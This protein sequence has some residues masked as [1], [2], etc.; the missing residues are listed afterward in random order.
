[1]GSKHH[2]NPYTPKRQPPRVVHAHHDRHLRIHF[3]YTP[4]AKEPLLALA[5]GARGLAPNLERIS[6]GPSW[7][8]FVP[9]RVKFPLSLCFLVFGSYSYTHS[10]SFTPRECVHFI[11]ATC[12]GFSSRCYKRA[13]TE[14]TTN[15]PRSKEPRTTA[16]YELTPTCWDF[17]S[18]R[19]KR[20]A[21][22]STTN[23]QRL[24]EPRT[25]ASYETI[26]GLVSADILQTSYQHV[27]PIVPNTSTSQVKTPW[28][29]A[30]YEPKSHAKRNAK[31]GCREKTLPFLPLL[32][33]LPFEF[34]T[35]SALAAKIP[36]AIFSLKA[37]LSRLC[38][39]VPCDGRME[40]GTVAKHAILRTRTAER[41]SIGDKGQTAQK[42]D[43]KQETNI[44]SHVPSAS[45]HS[46]A[47]P[48]ANTIVSPNRLSAE[49]AQP[50]L[51]T[52][53]RRH[54]AIRYRHCRART[55]TLTKSRRMSGARSQRK[56]PSNSLREAL[57][58]KQLQQPPLMR[59]QRDAEKPQD[60][61][62][63]DESYW[64]NE[65]D[66]R[67]SSVHR[68][69]PFP[70]HL[71]PVCPAQ[72]ATSTSPD[73][74]FGI[75]GPSYLFH[76]H[77]EDRLHE[78]EHELRGVEKVNLDGCGDNTP[79]LLSQPAEENRYHKPGATNT[80]AG[81]DV[82]ASHELTVGSEGRI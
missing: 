56:T 41:K 39:E 8:L 13:A 65:R 21:T 32:R 72:E 25:T 78:L 11:N 62:E 34:E 4:S 48:T 60:G 7:P 55:T 33:G 15:E 80:K 30:R 2:T 70:I 23:E 59:L 63:A 16:S 20:A 49:S 29:P 43:G 69:P 9:D 71:S 64:D 31:R 54:H 17:S 75:L 14:S 5:T 6:V 76:Q 47:P 68:L 12:W 44:L 45:T 46:L 38:D 22:G 77:Q 67:H 82:S 3:N 53:E 36:T 57:V 35:T 28:A 50:L 74:Q 42:D 58:E 40:D 19:D 52:R 81:S 26:L 24:K 73:W 1:M 18:H 51:Q 79:R 10:P 37:S 61:R 66:T 27:T